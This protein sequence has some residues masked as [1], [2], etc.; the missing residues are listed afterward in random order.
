V[1]QRSVRFEQQILAM[2]GNTPACH[3]RGGTPVLAATVDGMDLDVVAE[4]LAHW[5]PHH[6]APGLKTLLAERVDTRRSL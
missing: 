1:L 6:V 4:R 2:P 3:Q 5:V